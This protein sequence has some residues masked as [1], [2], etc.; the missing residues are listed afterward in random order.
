MSLRTGD[1][2][3]SEERWDEKDDPEVTTSPSF[4]VFT[5]KMAVV[6]YCCGDASNLTHCA[7]GATRD[8]ADGGRGV[9]SKCVLSRIN[10]HADVN[11]RK[12]LI[13]KSVPYRRSEPVTRD[14]ADRQ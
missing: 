10:N 12:M 13:K 2:A 6:P 11:G 9:W 7:T 1:I 4:P 14:L 8:R 3:L 5:V